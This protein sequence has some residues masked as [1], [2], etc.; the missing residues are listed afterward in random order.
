VAGELRY[1]PR[2]LRTAAAARDGIGELQDAPLYQDTAVNPTWRWDGA[3][4]RGEERERAHHP[5]REG[6]EGTI[7][8]VSTARQESCRDGA[9]KLKTPVDEPV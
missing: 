4:R 9:M 8:Q 7:D 1:S 5:E 6:A 3:A 2:V